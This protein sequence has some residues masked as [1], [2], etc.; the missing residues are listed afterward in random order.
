MIWQLNPHDQSTLTLVTAWDSE[1]IY[2][3]PNGWAEEIMKAEAILGA[4][5][6]RIVTTGVDLDKIRERWETVSV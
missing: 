1:S 3:N 2:E 6:I 4:R 5:W